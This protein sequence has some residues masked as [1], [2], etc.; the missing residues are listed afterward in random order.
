VVGIAFQDDVKKGFSKVKEDVLNLKRSLNRGL[1]AVE[2][3]GDRLH[4]FV[5]KEEFYTFIKRLG[6]RLEKIE[7]NLELSS[8]YE[9]EIKEVASRVNNLDK[10]LSRQ[11]NLSAEIKEVRKLRGRLEGLEGSAVKVQNFND[12][13]SKLADSIASVKKGMLTGI[14]F[15]NVKSEIADVGKKLESLEKSVPSKEAVSGN[16]DA[17]KSVRMGFERLEG[18]NKKRADSV[19]R[20]LRK[21][22]ETVKGGSVEKGLFE[23]KIGDI[24][25]EL[26]SLKSLLDSSVSEVDLSDYATKRELGKKISKVDE[27]KSEVERLEN[28]ISSAEGALRYIKKNA[29]SLDDIDRIGA[30]IKSVSKS[31]DAMKAGIEKVSEVVQNRLDKKISQMDDKI[32]R[33]VAKLKSELLERIGRVSKGKAARKPGL[34]SKLKAGVTEFFKEE[35]EP[36]KEGEDKKFH[37]SEF[38]KDGEGKPGRGKFL[39]VGGVILIILI[40]AL[41]FYFSLGKEMVGKEGQEEDLMEEDIDGLAEEA[42]EDAFEELPGR[43]ALKAG[44]EIIEEAAVEISGEVKENGEVLSAEGSCKEKYECRESPSGGYW[45]NCYVDEEET[46]RCFVTDAEGCGVAEGLSEDGKGDGE[47]R[48][49]ALYL[50]IAAVVLAVMIGFYVISSRNDKKNGPDKKKESGDEGVDLEEFFQKK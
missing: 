19:E 15:E 25:K 1:L 39:L 7:A 35:E 4:A 49:N 32:G 47:L 31:I 50:L 12:E 3:L 43:E 48:N 29:A 34:F 23:K 20:D 27:V 36:V 33:D 9:E 38:L 14:V 22:I 41:F 28:S 37:V 18:E 13:T 44:E 2:G 21:E 45:F 30:D 11:E 26:N 24:R 6:D 46:C 10:K 8:A 16:L 17:I 42:A 40:A 5:V